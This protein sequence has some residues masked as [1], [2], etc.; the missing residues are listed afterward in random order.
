VRHCLAPGPSSWPA[1]TASAYCVRLGLRSKDARLGFP[2]SNLS[3]EFSRF[4]S[5]F[6]FFFNERIIIVLRDQHAD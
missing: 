6:S 2:F 3:F 5:F 4:F 1:C